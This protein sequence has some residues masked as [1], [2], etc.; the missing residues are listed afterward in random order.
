MKWFFISLLA[1][2]FCVFVLMALYVTSDEEILKT[3]DSLAKAKKDGLVKDGLIPATINSTA[4]KI[5]ISFMP[6]SS[7]AYLSFRYK[8][9]YPMDA[10][11][12]IYS[13]NSD[14][15][16][17]FCKARRHFNRQVFEGSLKYFELQDNHGH[18]M[19]L[20]VDDDAHMAYLAQ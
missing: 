19:Y 10:S 5:S 11:R 14:I 15:Q 18:T 9:S 17:L 12:W 4:T 7:R 6:D 1:S 2:L 20:A 8:G 3:Y 16:Q 13:V